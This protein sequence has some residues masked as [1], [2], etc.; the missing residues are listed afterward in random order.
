[1]AL[2][3]LIDSEPEML[4]KVASVSLHGAATSEPHFLRALMATPKSCRFTHL[5]DPYDVAL[6]TFPLSDACHHPALGSLKPTVAS[7]RVFS[8]QVRAA[9]PHR[10]DYEHVAGHEWFSPARDRLNLPAHN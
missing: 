6:A 1:M 9:G 4:A 5:Y 7:K 10:H 2:D 3:F 8:L